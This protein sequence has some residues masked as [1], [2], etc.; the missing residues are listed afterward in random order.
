MSD[1]EEYKPTASAEHEDDDDFV[2]EEPATKKQKSNAGEKRKRGESSKDSGDGEHVFQ[3]SNKRR[4]AVR[5]FSNGLPSVDIRETY[6]DKNT[7]ELKYGKGICLPLNQW[8]T[9]K[10]LM[11]DIDEA[12][13]KIQKK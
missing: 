4:I 6:T 12:I 3:L 13:K 5:A 9:L 10:E 11:P 1:N 7:G 8:E 2:E